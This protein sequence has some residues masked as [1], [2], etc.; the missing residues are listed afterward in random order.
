MVTESSAHFVEHLV[1]AAW[2][3][4]HACATPEPLKAGVGDA[5]GA[6]LVMHCNSRA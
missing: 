2:F 1:N 6:P 3:V 4:C 5:Q